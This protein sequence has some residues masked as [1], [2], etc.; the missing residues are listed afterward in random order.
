MIIP[1][2][3]DFSPASMLSTL[4]TAVLDAAVVFR[5]LSSAL[6]GAPLERQASRALMR[7]LALKWRQFVTPLPAGTIQERPSPPIGVAVS[8]TGTRPSGD[9][10]W[11]DVAAV[12]RVGGTSGDGGH[13]IDTGLR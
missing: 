4:R 11:L 10:A 13:P 12:A 9:S 2:P 1:H 8:G 5:D 7:E 3:A 6:Q